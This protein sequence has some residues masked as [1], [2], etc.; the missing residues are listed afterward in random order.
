[1]AE[2]TDSL[3]VF[4]E[5]TKNWLDDATFK[6]EAG[7]AQVLYGD[8]ERIGAVPLVCIEP[9]AKSRD[10]VGLPRKTQIDFEVFVLMY[11]GTLENTQTNRLGADR[12]AEAVET[13]LH[14]NPNCDG[15]VVH[16]L[17]VRLDSGAVN[18]GGSMIR[19]SRLTW[20]AR[21]QLILPLL[22]A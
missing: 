13:R 18:K 16:S 4:A 22:G 19:A 1:M 12:L 10:L 7:I 11:F 20:T 2:L 9:S 17:A 21:S 14:S 5:W 8:Q 3:T 15:L 6:Q